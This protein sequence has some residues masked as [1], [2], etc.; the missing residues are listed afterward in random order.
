MGDQSSVD[1]ITLD[2][3][4]AQSLERHTKRFIAG[5][6]SDRESF[7]GAKDKRSAQVVKDFANYSKRIILAKL[8]GMEVE[9][10]HDDPGK[11][12]QPEKQTSTDNGSN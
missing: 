7:T 4:T 5:V 11:R 2:M 6:L 10:V 1:Q 8:T 9:S 3:F 12:I